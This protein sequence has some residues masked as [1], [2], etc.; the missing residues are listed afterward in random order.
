MSQISG[1]RSER[2][3][4][5][6][7]LLGCVLVCSNQFRV[8][9]RIGVMCSDANDSSPVSFNGTPCFPFYR[10]RESTGYSGG[11]EENER[12]K[13]FRIVGS[14]FSYMRVPPTL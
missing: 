11:R 5:A 10:P 3:P 2:V 6:R 4:R 9:V 8:R 14:F 1:E 13:S 7:S 12:K